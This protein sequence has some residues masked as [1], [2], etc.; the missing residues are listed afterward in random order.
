MRAV[1]TDIVHVFFALPFYVLFALSL[2]GIAAWRAQRGSR[3]HRWRYAWVLLGILVYAIGVEAVPAAILA[4][5]ESRYAAPEITAQQRRPDNVIIVLTAGWLRSTP[6]GYEQKLGEAGWERTVAAVALWRRIG[7]RLL[8][9]GAP[10]P[11]GQ[12][13]AA[14]TMARL[15]HALGV[16]DDALLVEPASLNTHENL[17]YSK[18]LLG[19]GRHALWLVTSAVHM[20]RSVAAARA[21]ELEVIPYP[22]DFRADQ[23]LT[24]QMLLPSNDAPAELEHALH[25]LVGMAAYRLLGWN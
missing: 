10:A 6:K 25:E 14:E 8:F 7:G 23:R 16:P 2:A 5:I 24:W 17:L 19:E 1:I 11:S 12:G 18:R 21:L 22:C 20:P 4:W 9:S 3:L 15:A 13:S